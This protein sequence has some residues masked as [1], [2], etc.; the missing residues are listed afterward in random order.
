MLK[1]KD[2]S[3]TSGDEVKTLQELVAKYNKVTDEATRATVEKL[4][5]TSIKQGQYPNDYFTE[6]TFARYE[7]DRMGKTISD[8]TFNDICVR[9]FTA[10]HKHIA[11]MMYRG[12][13][14]HVEQMQ[15]TMRHLL[16]DNLSRN[17]GAKGAIAGRGI[18]ITVEPFTGYNVGKNGH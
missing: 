17:D 18:A 11:A 14:F 6:K 12:P 2:G 15:S 5:N 10:E 4:V 9:G 7:I 13:T 16:L 1:H 8:R 3:G